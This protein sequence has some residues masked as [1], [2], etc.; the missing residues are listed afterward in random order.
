[1]L[2]LAILAGGLATRLRPITETVPKALVPVAG[3]PS[4]SHQLRLVRER[5]VE[6]VVLCVAYLG[7]MVRDY[8]GDGSQFGLHVDYSWDGGELLGTAGAVRKAL[9]LLGEAFLLM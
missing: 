6:R 4:I 2:S 3:E 1:M 7:E 5:G 9:P 8:V